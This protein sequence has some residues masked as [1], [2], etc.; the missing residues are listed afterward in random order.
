MRLGQGLLWKLSKTFKPLRMKGNLMILLT[1][2][3]RIIPPKRIIFGTKMNIKKTHN[4]IKS[5][6]I[7]A[8]FVFGNSRGV[9]LFFLPCSFDSRRKTSLFS[10]G[11]KVNPWIS[12]NFEQPISIRLGCFLQK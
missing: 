6:E 10:A 12:R 11:L 5:L 4:T 9:K 2:S 8:F 3:G 7:E 1:K